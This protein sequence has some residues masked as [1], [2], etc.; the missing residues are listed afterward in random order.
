MNNYA[1]ADNYAKMKK[2]VDH[3]I[4]NVK[5]VRDR[6]GYRENLGYDYIIQLQ[7]SDAY[8]ALKYSSQAEIDSYFFSECDRI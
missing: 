8:Q 6:F 7:E 1:E 5:R 3:I 4:R 2:Y